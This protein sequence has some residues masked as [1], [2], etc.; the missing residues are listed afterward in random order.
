[1]F[2]QLS[3]CHLPPLLRWRGA[4]SNSSAFLPTHTVASQTSF[5]VVGGGHGALRIWSS[6]PKQGKEGRVL[7]LECRTHTIRAAHPNKRRLN[8][9]KGLWTV[10][11]NCF[12][13]KNPNFF[14]PNSQDVVSPNLLG[15]Q[16]R[17]P[18]LSI[19]ATQKP[20]DWSKSQP[21]EEFWGFAENSRGS[22]AHADMFRDISLSAVLPV[23]SH[24][25]T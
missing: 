22:G 18:E 24:S 4:C 3:P 12:L 10:E 25:F 19:L 23:S 21:P 1:M 2:L 5:W 11:E 13:E 15:W 6:F 9:N 14:S 20:T 8:A 17:L 16:G 7:L